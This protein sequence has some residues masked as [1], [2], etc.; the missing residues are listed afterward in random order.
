[1]LSF[2]QYKNLKLNQLKGSDVY[3]LMCLSEN[4]DISIS[5][6]R[7]IFYSLRA[8]MANHMAKK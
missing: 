5:I 8:T 4:M 6:S 1:M 7:Y 3:T 2:Y